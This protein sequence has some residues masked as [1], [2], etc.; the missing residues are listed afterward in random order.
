MTPIALT[1]RRDPAEVSA[2]LYAHLRA[3]AEEIGGRVL[4]E[5]RSFEERAGAFVL[6]MTCETAGP[7]GRPAADQG[8]EW[9]RFRMWTGWTA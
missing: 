9:T 8:E 7:I 5:T 1:R 6:R 3:R 4:S 2:E